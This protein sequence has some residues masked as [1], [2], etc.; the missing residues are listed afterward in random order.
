[1]MYTSQELMIYD[2]G[3]KTLGRF[4]SVKRMPYVIHMGLSIPQT[5]TGSILHGLIDRSRRSAERDDMTFRSRAK[6]LFS[7]LRAHESEVNNVR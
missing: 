1:M 2:I 6:H 5:N 3:Y 4:W 7:S